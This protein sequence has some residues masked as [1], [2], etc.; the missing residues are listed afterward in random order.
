M[1][2]GKFLGRL[3]LFLL[4]MGGVF[5]AVAKVFK[6]PDP[7]MSKPVNIFDKTPYE[8]QIRKREHKSEYGPDSKNFDPENPN[9]KD[10][11]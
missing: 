9:L 11:E 6:Q 5:Q 10:D 4:P 3:F 8:E 2:I 1:S 7:D